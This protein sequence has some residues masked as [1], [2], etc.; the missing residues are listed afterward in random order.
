MRRN[1]NQRVAMATVRRLM[2]I[3]FMQERREHAGPNA[4]HGNTSGA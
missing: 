1:M 2:T 3:T 4:D